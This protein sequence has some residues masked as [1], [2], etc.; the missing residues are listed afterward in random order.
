M[1]ISELTGKIAAL[2]A[3]I[4]S[5]W[6]TRHE[7][8]RAL[9]KAEDK[10]RKRYRRNVDDAYAPIGELVGI[11]G[12]VDRLA[13]LE[14]DLVALREN[15]AGSAP[16]DSVKRIAQVAK[17]LGAVAGAGKI[18]S[19][20]SRARRALRRKEPDQTKALKRLDQAIAT[21]GEE[22]AWRQRAKRELL[23]GLAAYEAAIR[24]TIG[25]RQ[26]PRLPYSRALEIASCTAEHRD[27][28][29]YF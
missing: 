16:A 23:P 9:Q 6:Q 26:Q 27:I 4:P 17:A 15:I 22:L 24:G 25:L 18:R 1:R 28:S 10:A 5:D 11:I 19:R 13:A 2:A 21:F 20:L 29:L 8:F 12:D 14:P 3:E 7:D